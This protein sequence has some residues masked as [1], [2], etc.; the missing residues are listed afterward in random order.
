MPFW[1]RPNA[2][3]AGVPAAEVAA[4]IETQ[5]EPRWLG[6]F[7]EPRVNVLAVNLALDAAFPAAPT[8]PRTEG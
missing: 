3:G 8:G 5:I 1:P 4:L 7:G 2:R 6:L